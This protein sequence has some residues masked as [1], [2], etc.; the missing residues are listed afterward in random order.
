MSGNFD[1][2]ENTKQKLINLLAELDKSQW[3]YKP[4]VKHLANFPIMTRSDL[5][6]TKMKKGFFKTSTSGSTGQPVTVEK[7]YMD[8]IW[9]LATNIREIIWRNWNTELS[10]A[11][12][13][14]GIKKFNLP[15]WGLPDFVF[16]KQGNSF[17]TGYLPIKELQ[18]WLDEKNPHYI[19][20]APSVFK[21][22]NTS[23]LTNFIDWKSTGELG[24]SNF[25]SEEC[26]TIALKCP[27]NPEVYHVMENQ[28]VE[29]DTDGGM[30]ITTFTNPYIMRYKNG[31][32]IEL[33][34]CHCGR[35]L[36]T[37]K[38][39]YGRVRNMFVT[40]SGDKVWPL[41][42]SRDY[43]EKFGIKQ[44]KAIQESINIVKLQI[45]SENLGEKEEE[46]KKLVQ[47]SLQYPVEVNIEYI[48]SFS[49]YKHEEFISL[50]N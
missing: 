8:Y 23:K 9:Y 3:N 20:C 49:H 32:H 35:K 10:F 11:S 37:I 34:E 5:Q 33:G 42:G 24:G 26:G 48:D 39:I 40:P 19:H 27:D 28:H 4:E 14:P 36:Q 41:I 38:K 31:D 12:I 2:F 15:T 25:S 13:K 44:F 22:L 47:N 21:M 50:L 16:A 6:K 18:S 1:F 30:I 17:F 45:I 29:V 43:Y 7:S 46:L